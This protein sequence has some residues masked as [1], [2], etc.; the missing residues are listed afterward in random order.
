MLNLAYNRVII[1]SLQA[2]H[3]NHANFGFP[4]PDFVAK[5][6]FNGPTVEFKYKA[7]FV[8]SPRYVTITVHI[9]IIH[10]CFQTWDLLGTLGDGSFAGLNQVLYTVSLACLKALAL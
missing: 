10:D 1:R 7:S 9:Q 8:M 6:L 4:A 2:N 3:V 5:A